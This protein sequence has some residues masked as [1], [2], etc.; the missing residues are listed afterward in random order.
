MFAN[1]AT[2]VSVLATFVA[3]A[4]S[5]HAAPSTGL[6]GRSIHRAVPAQFKEE[7]RNY[8]ADAQLL[9][10]YEDYNERYELFDCASKHNTTFWNSCC[11]PLLKNQT[12]DILPDVCFEDIPCDSTTTTSSHIHTTTSEIVPTSTVKAHTTHAPTTSHVASTTKKHTTTTTKAPTST[13]KKSDAD[14]TTSVS[15]SGGGDWRTGGH[16]TYF[17]Q[18]GN[19]GACGQ[20]HDDDF[21]LVAID[22]D[23]YGNKDEVSSYCGKTVEIV[24]LANGKSIQA[25]VTDV[26]PSCDSKNCLDLS[27]G[28]FKALDSNLSDGEFNIKYRVL[29]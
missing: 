10:P 29:S 18:E 19:Y 7:K 11:H 9:E 12:E 2:I 6:A 4:P 1:F 21:L 17:Y 8:T 26:C 27:V 22:I 14:P 24:N 23:Y 3:V 16:A 15:S 5:A 20:K 13:S 28:A 25:V